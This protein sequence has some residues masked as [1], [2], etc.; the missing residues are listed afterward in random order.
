[1]TKRPH[2]INQMVPGSWLTSWPP[3]V[4]V[5]VTVEDQQRAAQRLPHLIEIPAPV[6][7]VS[8]EPLLGPLDL[9][10]WLDK[11]D[12]VIVGGE[13]GAQARPAEIDWVR[14]LR[15]QVT[16]A[17]VAFFFK[18]WGNWAQRE[19]AGDK[20]VKLTTKTFR[21]L[22]GRQWDEFPTPRAR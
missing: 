21:V 5:G 9:S 15:D 22:D 12:W 4:W 2:A 14:K 16:A 7:F 1:M 3:N 8:V 11:L 20:L 18:Q 13:S 6:R 19:G 17:G 10:P